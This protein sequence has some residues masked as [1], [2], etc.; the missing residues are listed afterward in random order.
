MVPRS[1]V[2]GGE[3]GMPVRRRLAVALLGVLGAGAMYA[4]GAQAFR[5]DTGSPDLKVSWD[6][7]VKYSLAARLR[8]ADQDVA[9]SFDNPNV[10]F[11]DRALDRGV[12]NNRFDLLSEFDLA[13]KNVGFRVSGAAW[14]DTVYV[15]SHNDYP[16]S[17]GIPNTQAALL[18]GRNDRNSGDVKNL[19]G[20]KAEF[21]DAFVYGSADLG[22]GRMLSGRAGK[23]TQLYGETLFLGANGIAYAQGP[24][25]LVKAF[26]LPN[27]QFKE[28][29]MPVG[30]VS[31][32]LQLSPDFSIGAY[33]QYDWKPLRLPAAGSYF[34]PADFVGDG[35]DLLLTPF[36]AANRIADQKGS[37]SGQFGARLKF[38]LGD[39]DLG[40][41]G[42]RFHEKVPIPV[43]DA[44]V[45]GRFGAGSYHL[46]Y[47][48]DIDVYGLSASTV[49]GETNVAAEIST[50]RNTPLA[51][52][53]DLIITTTPGTNN[54]RDTPYARGSTFHL[55]LSAITLLAAN[56]LWE[57]ASFVGEFAYNRLLDVKHNPVNALGLTALNT[58]HTRD[59]GAMR[60]V[61]QPEYFQ[62]LPG[63]DLQ[64]PIGVGYGLFGRSAVF[65]LAPEHG[66]DI[67]IGVNANIRNTWR[68][69]LNVTHY[70]GPAGPAP[71]LP[72]TGPKG[73]Y[74]SYKQ[75]YA[76][77]D[78]VSI[79]V[80]RTF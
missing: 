72:A 42:A 50:R 73:T 71:S 12:I 62:V 6:N 39:Y 8:D 15:R 45:P 70:F 48:K 22:S 43:I 35:A 51:P 18:G 68:A 75:Y 74:A 47:A 61:F 27:A 13:Y 16:D 31:G 14:Y 4:P 77:R 52:L 44:T 37:D 67:S 63:V 9:A 80:Q 59:H 23:H 30:Q 10:D 79:S 34:S 2:V 46:A 36:G 32:N 29:A 54:K 64:V 5:F 76:D 56:A 38:R 66:G 41:Y 49:I 1:G 58:T 24:V 19:M 55:N 57:G 60:F 3:G 40:V 20:R 21:L 11:G 26:S 7:T 69:S 17:I 53:G 65:Q 25:D 28:I 78:Y 33:V